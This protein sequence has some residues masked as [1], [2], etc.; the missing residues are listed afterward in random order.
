M[1]VFD[2]TL[3]KLHEYIQAAMGWTNSHLHHFFVGGRRCGEPELLDD[4]L[5]P[6]TGIDSTKTL[7]SALLPSDSAP[8]SFEYHY[9]FGDSWVHDVHF[10][11]SPAPQPG[12]AYPQ[13]LEGERACPPEDVGGTGGYTEYLE[14]MADPSHER[15]QEMLDWNGP[16][17]PNAFN[18]RLATHVMQEGIPDWRKMA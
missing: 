11:G 6:F 4:D 14:A 16:F 13:C 12:V 17:N 9:D 10:E 5:E 1:Q 8:I 7:I 3:D 2:D 18:P 15:H